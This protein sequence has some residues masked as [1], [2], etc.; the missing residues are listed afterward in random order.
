MYTNYVSNKI[1][2]KYPIT[3][4]GLTGVQFFVGTYAKYHTIVHH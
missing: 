3:I 4:H 1:T 2:C